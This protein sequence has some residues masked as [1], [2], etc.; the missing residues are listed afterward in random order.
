MGDSF[1][2]NNVFSRRWRE[3]Q[4]V[5][6]PFTDVR[7]SVFVWYCLINVVTQYFN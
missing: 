7:S 1:V 4:T 5:C 6:A 3:H 2:K